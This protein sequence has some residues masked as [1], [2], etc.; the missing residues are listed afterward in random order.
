MTV[1]ILIE[2]NVALR[3]SG[4]HKGSDSTKFTREK[5]TIATVTFSKKIDFIL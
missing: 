3:N 1:I 5:P 4:T 2:K